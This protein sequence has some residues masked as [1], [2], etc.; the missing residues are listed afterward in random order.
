MSHLIIPITVTD[1]VDDVD[2]VLLSFDQIQIHRSTTG[3]DGAHVEITT[4]QTRIPLQSGVETYAFEDKEGSPDYS[5]RFRFFNS[6][7]QDVGAFSDPKLGAPDP[8]LEIISIDELKTNYLFGLDLTNDQGEPFPDSL[9]EFYIRSAVSWLEHRLDIPI[10]RTVIEEER[11]DYYREDYDKYIWLQLY[12]Y[13]LISIEELRLVLPG[14]QVVQVFEKDWIH[15]QRDSGQVQLVPGTG[16]AGSIL[17]G[18][19]AAW[20]PLIYGQNSFIPDAFRVKYTAGFGPIPPG[21]FGFPQG[22]NPASVSVP[23]PELDVV[24]PVIKE[25]VGKLASYGPLNI[26]GDLLGGAGIASQSIG[27]DGLS[28]SFN[29]TSSSTSSGF[30][31]RL[32]QYNREVKEQLPTLLNYY[33]RGPKLTVV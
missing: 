1:E 26:A 12:R 19:S 6:G 5:Y 31:S 15:P 30:G 3:I 21:S 22:S 28:Q 17:L 8:A 2:T 20:I 4:A 33:K 18:A 14:E 10:K 9:F 25:L 27:I 16:T 13:P 11:H 23:Y 24:P 7:T 32:I 29:T